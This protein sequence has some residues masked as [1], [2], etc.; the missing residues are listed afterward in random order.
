MLRLSTET[1]LSFIE[2]SLAP[3]VDSGGRLSVVAVETRPQVSRYGQ[4]AR[5]E[6]IQSLVDLLEGRTRS[7]DAW[8]EHRAARGHRQAATPSS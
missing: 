4:T 7:P 6:V 3:D 5:R 1:G 8:K 2:L